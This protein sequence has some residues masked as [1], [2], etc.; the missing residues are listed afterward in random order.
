MIAGMV[1]T[2]IVLMIV[3]EG[4]DYRVLLDASAP[5]SGGLLSR[6]LWLGLLGAAMAVIVWRGSLC[7]QLLRLLNPFLLLF[8]ALALA[9]VVWSIEPLFTARRDLRLLTIVSVCIA[10]SL[11]GW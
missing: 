4:F 6:A 3:P 10:F 9:S 7:S 8:V 11:S 5:A 1:W 2:L